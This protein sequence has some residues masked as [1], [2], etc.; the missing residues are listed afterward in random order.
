M[1]SLDFLKTLAQKNDG[2]SLPASDWNKIIQAV[3]DGTNTSFSTLHKAVVEVWQDNDW[4][5][6]TESVAQF[7]TS[8]CL[9]LTPGNTYRLSGCFD[10]DSINAITF[11]SN[12]VE[13]ASSTIV[14]HNVFI[15]NKNIKSPINFPF[16]TKSLKIVVDANTENYIVG[17]TSLDLACIHS[18]NNMEVAGTGFLGLYNTSG[19]G[20]KASELNI[21]GDV[22]IY[23][24]VAHD[25][26]HGTKIV[27]IQWGQ[28][29]IDSAKDA[30][31]TGFQDE[32]DTGKLRGI[33]RVF[34]GKFFINKLTDGTVFDAKYPYMV[35]AEGT[36]HTPTEMSENTV[37]EDFESTYV[38]HSGIFSRQNV[39]VECLNISYNLFPNAQG[40]VNYF[41][42]YLV[43]GAG[44][45]LDNGVE[46]IAEGGV[47]NC[48]STDIVAQGKIEG[49]I[50]LSAQSTEVHL[51]RAILQGDIVIEYTPSNK[52]PQI[53]IDKNS[54]ASYIEGAIIS[55]N[56]LKL[57]PK[58]EANL[59]F[60]NCDEPIQ[61]STIN[62]VNGGGNIYVVD[63][64]KGIKGTE[65]I[66]GVEEGVTDIEKVFS[67]NVYAFNNASYSIHARLNK[68]G[69]KK[70]TITVV[71]MNRGT[72]YVDKIYIEKSIE[73]EILDS[74]GK[75]TVEPNNGKFYYQTLIGGGFARGAVKYFNKVSGILNTYFE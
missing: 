7:N 21:T 57:T 73:E 33:I 38:I 68:T 49:K 17:D 2:D 72:V 61:A 8:G 10:M 48:T 36:Y 5:L 34:G 37:T 11:T 4:K 29:Y 25:A 35:Y 19:H 67:G 51:Q 9:Y 65:Y 55:A 43:E 6:D 23:A 64:L 39:S 46:V 50:V 44:K 66:I 75:L 71:P 24:N 20:I 54:E 13:P 28:Y 32:E 60:R 52:Q 53:Q 22:K 59:Y 69:K 3:I 47:Y 58:K 31:G 26:L 27:N 16:E 41:R 30:V 15:R 12:A 74:T 18:Y 45:V 56:N 14:L 40:E 1:N 70:G 62:I 42:E 63:T